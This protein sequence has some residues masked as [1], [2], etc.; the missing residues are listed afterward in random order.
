[1]LSEKPWRAETVLLFLGALLACWSSGIL[2]VG[3]L[4]HAGIAGF[5]QPEDFGNV[6]VVTLS[7]QGMTWVLIPFFLRM[8]HT[9]WRDAF[10]FSFKNILRA[11]AL[12]L[13]VLV[14][15]LPVVLFLEGISEAVLEKAGWPVENQAPVKL[16]LDAKT[17]WPQ[18]Y[19][20]VFA[21]VIAPVAEEFIFR[22]VLY[23][24][25]K[26]LGFPRL[27]WLGV[28]ALFAFIH[29]DAARFM[30]L[31]A[32]AL[33]LTWLYEFTDSLLAPIAA[34]SLFNAVNFAVLISQTRPFHP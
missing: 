24:F 15:I 20:C 12:A 17:L 3:A 21:V 4:H 9:R 22:G 16:V 30:P 2:A 26:Q 23:P 10:G 14:V 1:M 6:L 25:V 32:L 5:K 13:A 11:L 19:L 7:F 33:A 29:L 31:F 34:H 8:H 18:V 28:S 27:A